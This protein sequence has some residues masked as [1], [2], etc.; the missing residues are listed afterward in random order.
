VFIEV[1]VQGVVSILWAVDD[2]STMLLIERFCTLRP[3]ARMEIAQALDQAQLWL[4]DVTAEA[5]REPFFEKRQALMSS[6]RIPAEVT[7]QQHRCSAMMDRNER[8]FANLGYWA[9]FTF[10]GA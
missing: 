1:G 4:Q 6:S 5:L 7:T 2:L 10:S 8:P 9:A 3:R